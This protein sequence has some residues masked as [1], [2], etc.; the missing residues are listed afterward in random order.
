MRKYLLLSLVCFIIGCTQKTVTVE[1]IEKN[2]ELVSTFNIAENLSASVLD[3]FTWNSIAKSTHLVP[4]SSKSI[5]GRAPKI[6]FLNENL[7]LVSE[8]QTQSINCYDKNGELK[9]LIQKVG[10]GP[11]EYKYLS[12][13]HYSKLDSTIWIYDSGNKKILTYKLNGEFV[14]EKNVK[15]IIGRT[16]SMIDEDGNFFTNQGGNGTDYIYQINKDLEIVNKYFSFDTVLTI[17]GKAG[18]SLMCNRSNTKDKYLVNIPTNDTLFSITKNGI[19]PLVVLQKST[20]NLNVD[21]FNN[22]ILKLPENNDF[23]TYSHIDLCSS[24]LLYR[25]FWQGEFFIQLWDIESNK[26]IGKLN[27]GKPIST[28]NINGGF[29]FIFNSGK[30]T[31]LLPNYVTDNTLV[32][33]IPAE[34]CV[35]EI[36]NV[37]EEDNPVL[38]IIDLK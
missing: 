27:L 5:L 36:E 32:F 37:K 18:F 19:S 21:L 24:L 3:T 15:D 9:V 31:R 29:N 38:L 10:Q 8:S 7:I 33:L 17:K 2:S 23:I 1:V 34:D 25:Y 6:E 26:L 30:K 13:V 14:Q 11:G 16:I 28:G 35:G 20:H 22:G 12:S 4:L